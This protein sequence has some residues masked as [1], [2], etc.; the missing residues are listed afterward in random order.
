[1]KLLKF[2]FIVILLMFCAS[3][4]L[5]AQDFVYTPINPSFG[6]NPM[7]YNWMITSA[8][9]QNKIEKSANSSMGKD[10]LD[11]FINNLN[12]QILSQ[13]SGRLVNNMFG[14]NGNV[15]T[16]VYNLGSYRINLKEDGSGVTVNILDK[17]NGN[18]TNVFI[19]R[20]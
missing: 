1:M 16:G 3:A 2:S 17:G 12:R 19:P 20:Y 6:G 9:Q 13:L 4:D 14:S 7:N 18:N 8:N 15:E 5:F 11:D 10:P